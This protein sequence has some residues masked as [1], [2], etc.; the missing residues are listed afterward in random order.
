RF[1]WFCVGLALF[2]L[3]MMLWLPRDAP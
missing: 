2:C 1:A 3:G